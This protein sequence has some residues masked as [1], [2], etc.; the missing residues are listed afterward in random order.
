[1]TWIK[2]QAHRQ[3]D[4]AHGLARR[5][6]TGS[7]IENQSVKTTEVRSPPGND[8]GKK[9]NGRVYHALGDTVERGGFVLEPRPASIPDRDRGGPL[10]GGSRGTFPFSRKVFADSGCAGEKDAKAAHVAVEILRKNPDQ[11]RFAVQSRRPVVEHFLAWIG[12]VRVV[13]KDFEAAIDS[14]RAFLYA[15][16][17][18][19][20]VRRPARTP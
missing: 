15:A 11:V 6:A 7:I 19:L 10:S 1:L 17:V 13:A 18:I 4:S 16:S 3:R 8:A 9:T 12:R 20:P 5:S 14:A 2:A